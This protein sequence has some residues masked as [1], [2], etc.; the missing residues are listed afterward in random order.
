[1][2]GKRLSMRKIRELLRL[3]WEFGQSNRQIARSLKISNSTVLECMRRAEKAGLSWPLP[4]DLDDVQLEELLYPPSPPSS[5]PRPLPDWEYVHKE[6]RRKDMTLQLLWVEYKEEHP[7]GYQYSQ[8]CEH[9]NRWRGKL[10]VVMRQTYKAGEKLFI[11]YAGQT[12]PIIDRETGEIREAQIFIGVMGA[13]N[14]PYV[15]ATRTQQLPDWISSHVRMFEYM[16]AVSAV[17]V[18]DNTKTGVKDASYYEP[19]LNPTYHEMAAHY[20][21]VVIPARPEKPRDKS[22][23]E[24]GVQLTERWILA[25]LRNHTFFSLLELNQEI[26]RLLKEIVDIPFQKLEGTRRS[27]FESVDRPAMRPLPATPYELARWKKARVGIDYHVQ[28]DYHFYSVPYQLARS[29]VEARYTA[30]AV[31]ILHKGHRVAAHVRSYERGR[32]TTDPAHM[33]EAHRKHLEWTPERLI[34]WAAKV[35]PSTADLARAIMEHR[36]HPEQGY[37]SCLGLMRL[38]KKYGGDRLEAACMRALKIGGNS[39][40]SVDSILKSGLDRSPVEEQQVM[41]LPAD[42]ANVRGAD[43]YAGSGGN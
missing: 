29:E 33:P 35:G 3:K 18:P 30:T 13:S 36:P 6:L 43:Y 40:R 39:Y 34:T 42:H 22:K 21:T 31:E 1:M 28:I 14:Y 7:D 23:V 11:D 24:A 10:D 9:Y 38:S 4:D 41:P 16:G 27:L 8:F 26:A 15:E 25:R 19:D 20:G 32:F 2:A 12:V 5:V 17:L 37:R